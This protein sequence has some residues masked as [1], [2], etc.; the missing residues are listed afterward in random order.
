MSYIIGAVFGGLVVSAFLLIWFVWH[1][2]NDKIEIVAS[3][4]HEMRDDLKGV[5]KKAGF[6]GD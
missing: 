5:R 2:L 6:N 3:A 1:D 4:I